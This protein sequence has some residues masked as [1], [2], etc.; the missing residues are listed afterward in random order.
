MDDLLQRALQRREELRAAL[1]AIENFI[2]SYPDKDREPQPSKP[3]QDLFSEKEPTPSK[4]SKA[5]QA[6]AVAAA[7]DEAERIIIAEGK[8]L[9]R[10]DLARRLREAGHELEG[11]DKNKV[12][13][14]NIW[15]SGRFWNLKGAG[16]WPRSRAIPKDFESLA[17][18]STQL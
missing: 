15:R 3:Q 17:I 16:Y 6:E 8:P 13:G 10:G 18:R 7:L 1:E 11:T 12:L 14:T 4:R 2:R 9:T 5:D